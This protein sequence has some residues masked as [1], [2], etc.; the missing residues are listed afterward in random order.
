MAR[1]VDG[2]RCEV[3]EIASFLFS[4]KPSRDHNPVAEM[5]SV[6]PEDTL[7]IKRQK[8]VIIS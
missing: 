4:D 7:C 1:G 5:R 3:V 6:P 2:G 8:G